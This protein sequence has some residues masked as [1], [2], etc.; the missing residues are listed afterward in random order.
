MPGPADD[1]P[2]S[3]E[4]LKA[5]VASRDLPGLVARLVRERSWGALISLFGHAGGLDG[6]G[7]IAL[8]SLDAATRALTVALEAV[9]PPKNARASLHDELRAVRI[10]AAEA[11]LA[12]GGHPPFTEIERRARRHAAALLSAA[13]D[14]GRA[15]ATHEALGD[16]ALAAEAWG[17]AGELDRMEAAHDREEARLGARR[18]AN[19]AMRRFEVLLAGGERRRALAVAAALPSGLPEAATARAQAARLESR[20]LRGRG[21]TLR[22]RGGPTV[23]LGGLPATLGRDPLCEI[24]LRDPGVSRQHAL[25]RQSDDGLVVEDR[26]S[27]GGLRVAGARVEG[28]FPLRGEGELALGA[29]TALRFVATAPDR[30]VLRGVAGLDRELVALVGPDPLDLS[31]VVEGASGLSVELADGSARLV[32]RPDL[33]VRVDGHFVGTGCDLLHGDIVEVGGATPLVVEVL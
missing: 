24:T 32:R 8:P 2:I 12:R 30:V 7:G 31:L 16:D 18:A 5:A 19:D 26:G 15:A 17:A 1:L 28:A 9:P 33:P 13:G 6:A 22:V 20:L 29:T 21:V 3:L 27:R 25:V 4:E 10:A 14:H 11:L 23:R